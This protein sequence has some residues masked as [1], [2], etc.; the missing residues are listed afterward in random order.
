MHK[1]Y[2]SM[3]LCDSSK[4]AKGDSVV[5]ANTYWNCTAFKNSVQ[6]LLDSRICFM[7]IVRNYRNVAK[8]CALE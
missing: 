8:V 4:L 1:A 2:L 6:G 5:A 7:D 3:L